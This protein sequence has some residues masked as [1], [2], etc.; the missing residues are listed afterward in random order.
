[1]GSSLEQSENYKHELQNGTHEIFVRYISVIREFLAQ[2]TDSIFVT[3]YTYYRY[4]ILKGI[5]TISHVFRIILLNT[6]N[7]EITCHHAQKAFYYYVEFIGQ[8]GE[9]THTYL[10]LSSKDATLFVYK[11]TIYEIRKDFSSIET[12]SENT[13]QIHKNIL[14]LIGIYNQ[15]LEYIFLNQEWDST[16]S[17]KLLTIVDTHMCKFTQNILSALSEDEHLYQ[18]IIEILNY[19]KD[20]V[21]AGPQ[22]VNKMLLLEVFSRKIKGKNIVDNIKKRLSHD[23]NDSLMERLTPLRYV[24]WLLSDK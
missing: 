19:V 15:C 17:S 20:K 1:M 2:C 21:F 14:M 18:N 4:I 23:Q 12:I 16:T 7:L 10:Q 5:E 24:N 13:K 6:N 11:K 9:E 8:I 3:N 22:C